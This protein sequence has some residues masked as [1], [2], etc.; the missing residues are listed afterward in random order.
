MAKF[1]VYMYLRSKDTEH[2]KEGTPY[3]VGK[4]CARRAYHSHGRRVSRPPSKENVVI[5]ADGLSEL[6]AFAEE[7]RLIALHGRISSGNGCLINLTNGGE[8]A[9]GCKYSA[10]RILLAS[11]RLKQQWKTGKRSGLSLLR[12]STSEKVRE[13]AR[14][15]NLGITFSDETR[16]K[17][18]LS[19]L[20]RPAMSNETKARM[21]QA[22]KG[23]KHSEETRIR[24]LR[25]W[26][27]RHEKSAYVQEVMYA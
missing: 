8:G 11:E 24:L 25:A 20:Q 13:R 23:M 3:Y 16:K 18:S 1:Y 7:K 12:H 19:A 22:H 6:E 9:S 4:G 26:D 17:M 27:I 10:E 5:V 15:M 14:T 21:S 2:G